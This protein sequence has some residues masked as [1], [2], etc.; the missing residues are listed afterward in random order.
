MPNQSIHTLVRNN[1]LVFGR[2]S[3]V[4]PTIL[5]ATYDVSKPLKAA[6]ECI[7]GDLPYP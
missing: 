6:F 3:T 1:G 4:K 7:F 5:L 2:I